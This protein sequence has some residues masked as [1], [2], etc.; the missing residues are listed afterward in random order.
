VSVLHSEWNCTVE[1][2]HTMRIGLRYVQGLQ[3]AHA[4]H[5][6][7]ARRAR[8][9]AS[10]ADFL[11]RVSLPAHERR[12]LAAVGAFAGLAEHRR[13]ALWQVEAAWSA[14]E[15]LFQSAALVVE[16]PPP[17]APMSPAERV[18]ADFAG[19]QLTTGAHPMSLVRDRL[20]GIW[21]AGDLPLGRDG[22]RVTIGGSVI[23]RQRPGTAKGVVFVSLED[24]T[25]VANAIV[26][27]ALFERHRLLI[28]EEPSLAITGRLQHRDG[29]IHVQAETIARLEL[30]ELPVQASHDFH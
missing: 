27:A 25:G 12:A 8:P 11:Q 10:L 19:L 2:D 16:D 14:E 23:C 21:R 29:V 18:Q 6:V 28:N 26:R 22:E 13:A 20:P 24:E 5:L 15:S 3:E 9:F 1:D 17:L 4:R 30:E 7:A